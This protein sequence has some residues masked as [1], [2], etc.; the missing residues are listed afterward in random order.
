M[1]S[2]KEFKTWKAFLKFKI[3]MSRNRKNVI[4]SRLKNNQN[5][6]NLLAGSISVLRE[7]LSTKE[8]VFCFLP[9]LLEEQGSR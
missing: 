9:S 1:V 2:Q 5:P 8:A 7:G 3:Y 4:R 6:T